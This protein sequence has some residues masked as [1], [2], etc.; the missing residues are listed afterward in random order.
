[1]IQRKQTVFLFLSL[2][3]T[4][5]CLS[6]PIALFEPQGMG[7]ENRMLNLWVIDSSGTKDFSVWPLFA[8]LLST[9]PLQLFAI[10]DYHHR[11]RQITTCSIDLILIIV[12]YI[13]YG[14]LSKTLSSGMIYH[15][16]LASFLPLLT[17]ILIF[18]ARRG[19]KA[20]EALVRAADR[21][22]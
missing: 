19:I 20:D 1:M 12:W 7:G 5:I 3:A 4:L 22:R 11:K 21:I 6:M 2:I 10:F 18:L 9:V 15:A 13:A 8:I 16:Q 17:L 14:V